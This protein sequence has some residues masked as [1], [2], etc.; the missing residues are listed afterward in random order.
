MSNKHLSR[1]T[2]PYASSHHKAV[3]DYFLY[4]SLSQ[5][6][7]KTMSFHQ[8]DILSKQNNKLNQK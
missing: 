2:L 3:K 1:N 6:N 7:P 8:I 5:K 4:E